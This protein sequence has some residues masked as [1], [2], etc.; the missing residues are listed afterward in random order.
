MNDSIIC[1]CLWQRSSLLLLFKY[2]VYDVIL[3]SV[4]LGKVTGLHVSMKNL[5]KTV[6]CH[7]FGTGHHLQHTHPSHSL[8]RRSQ[9]SCNLGFRCSQANVTLHSG[10]SFDER[11]LGHLHVHLFTPLTFRG[12]VRNVTDLLLEELLQMPVIRT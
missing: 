4:S 11:G 5:K 8:N 9:S 6:K 2:G 12:E 1:G 10:S 7:L 3:K